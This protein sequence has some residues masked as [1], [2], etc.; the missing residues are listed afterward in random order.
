MTR[1]NPWNGYG[2]GDQMPLAGYA[3]LLGAWVGLFGSVGYGLAR[4]RML[5]RLRGRD[6]ALLGIATHKITRIATKDWVT[7]PLRASFTRYDGSL[8]SGEVKEKSRGRGLR[9]AMGDLLT[10][11]YCTGPWVAGALLAAWARAPDATRTVAVLFTAVATSDFLHETYDNLRS[12]RKLV[13]ARKSRDEAE[14]EVAAAER[15]ERA[16]PLLQTPAS[17]QGP[18]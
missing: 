18:A 5:P 15:D 12:S 7:A 2:G 4:R 8:G 16:S 17:A 14:Q 9:R 1:R 11:N 6:I 10:C 3:T 13:E